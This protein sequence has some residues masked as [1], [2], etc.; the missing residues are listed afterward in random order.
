MNGPRLTLTATDALARELRE[1]ANLDRSREGGVWEAPRIA[2]LS[3]WLT[4]TWTS[5]WPEAQLLSATQELVLWRDAVENDR[6]TQVLSPLAAA[7]EA[8]RA[9]QLLRNYGMDGDT[10]PTG[11]DEHDAFRRWR[12]EVNRRLRKHQWLTAADIAGEA[13]RLIREGRVALPREVELAGFTEPLLPSEQRV[14]E[15]LASRGTQVVMVPPQTLVPQLEHLLQEDDLAQFRHVVHAV[16]EQL[17]AAGDGPPPRIVIALPDPQSRRPLLESVLRD[18]LAPW[19]ARGEGA[20]PWRWDQGR[21]L[22]EQPHVDAMLAIL[23]LAPA[24][25]PQ[26]AVSRV[27]LSAALWTE[28]ER[29]HTA[30][31]DLRLRDQS[32]PHVRLRFLAQ[33]LPPALAA[34]FERLLQVMASAAPRALPSQWADQF[35]QRLEALGWPGS[36]PPDSVTFQAERSACALLDRLGTLDAQLGRIA[37]SAAR[38]WLGE[39]A[40]GAHFQPR[41]EHL[42]PVLITSLEAAASLGCD[43]LYVLD[44]AAAQVPSAA[45]ATPFVP[46][47]RQRAAG[48]PEASPEA[49]LA[50]ARRQAARLLGGCAPRVC[51]CVARTDER[52]SE[53]QPSTLFGEAARWRPAHPALDIGALEQ[54]LDASRTQAEWPQADPVPPVAEAERAV[55]RCD[56]S[57]FKAWFESPFFAFCRY[58][59]G[60]Q[61]LPQPSQG[62]DARVQGTLL[63]KVLE[64][65]WTAV[66]G[67]APLAALDDAALRERLETLVDASLP[68]FLPPADYG[69]ATVRLERARALD[70]LLQWLGHERRRVDPFVV[71]ACEASAEPTVGGLV[72]RLRLDRVDRVSTPQ[73]ERWLVIDYKTGRQADP[74]GWKVDRLLEP[75]LPLYAGFAARAAAEV[76]AVHGICFAHLK[77]GHPALV[78]QT[79]WRRKLI[80]P[81]ETDAAVEWGHR[82]IDWRLALEAAARGF[83][84]GDAWVDGRVT[85]RSHF[86]DLLAFTS[87]TPDEE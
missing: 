39:L 12:T 80:E 51:V 78:A 54:S 18:L 61:P 48:V 36:Q 85:G 26:D 17:R 11:Q 60:I 33:K 3:R 15:A 25:N 14:L 68:A 47:E 55:L 41:V 27:L 28:A 13:A 23:Q 67:S 75:Q 74:K 62:P 30:A 20:L 21:P 66:R 70:L 64:K 22:Q 45:R 5:S 63:H 31:A 19:A 16:R 53:R 2:S 82:L 83:L 50:R 77:D 8:R 10:P 49:W 71:H 38:E 52:G 7:R 87:T 43:Q 56:S 44:V 79:S 4:E 35:R 1:Q 34:R 84:A 46:L 37:E 69:P 42:Q 72:L 58:R 29:L 59:L 76:P 40:R 32:P 6:A 86:A 9:D 73:G 81:E 65:F 24:R 57:L